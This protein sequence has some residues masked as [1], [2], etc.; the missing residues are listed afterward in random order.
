MTPALA[1]S[2]YPNVVSRL[3]VSEIAQIESLATVSPQLVASAA[4]VTRVRQLIEQD[5]IRAARGILATTPPDTDTRDLRRLRKALKIPQATMVD[6]RDVDGSPDFEWLRVHGAEY[7]GK[8]VALV[9]GRLVGVGDSLKQAL[10]QS[11][12][13]ASV[14]PLVHHIPLA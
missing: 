1:P 11:D 7:R 2:D 8:W 4:L 3:L 5:C 13:D 14:R 12:I 6:E 10:E 9:G